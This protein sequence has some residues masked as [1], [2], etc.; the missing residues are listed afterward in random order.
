MI[1]LSHAMNL[2]VTAEGVE[3]EYHLQESKKLHVDSAQGY[4]LAQ[5]LKADELMNFYRIYKAS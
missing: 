2:S 3:M 4:F 5:A 1:A